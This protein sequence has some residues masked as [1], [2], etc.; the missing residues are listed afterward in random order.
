MVSIHMTGTISANAPLINV[1][2]VARCDRVVASGIGSARD[3]TGFDIGRSPWQEVI[4]AH[5]TPNYL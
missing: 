4:R 1:M 5:V 2:Y 3:G